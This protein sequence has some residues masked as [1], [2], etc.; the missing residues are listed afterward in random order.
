MYNK[1]KDI[2]TCKGAPFLYL[3]EQKATHLPF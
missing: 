2:L 1:E 3:T